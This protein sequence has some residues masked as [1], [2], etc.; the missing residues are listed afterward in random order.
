[1]TDDR[2]G[3]EGV[4]NYGL[5]AAVGLGAAVAWYLW[6]RGRPARPPGGAGAHARLVPLG[7]ARREAEWTRHALHHSVEAKQG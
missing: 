6:P 4:R 2:W 7:Q 3:L 5:L 1:M